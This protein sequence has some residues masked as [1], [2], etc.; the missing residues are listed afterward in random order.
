[1]TGGGT[2]IDVSN[3]F[4]RSV[5][6][7]VLA[8]A[9]RLQM[10]RGGGRLEAHRRSHGEHPSL[11]ARIPTTA[12]ATNHH[13]RRLH[14]GSDGSDGG[15]REPGPDE[16]HR[17]EQGHESADR[18]GASC[19]MTRVYSHLWSGARDDNHYPIINQDSEHH[20]LTHDQRSRRA[21]IEKYIM[22]QYAN[23][24]QT[25]KDTTMGATNLLDQTIIYGIS[26]CQAAGHVMKDSTSC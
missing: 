2:P 20:T 7:A 23:L 13:R 16:G 26:E 5:L 21:T 15:S 4:R 17:H 14:G 6:D 25:L 1:M 22:G 10:S 24:A 3:K 9:K 18:G 19:N 12:S 11:E 8:D